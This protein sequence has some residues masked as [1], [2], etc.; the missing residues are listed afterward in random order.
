MESEKEWVLSQIDIFCGVNYRRR[1]LKLAGLEK[2][3]TVMVKLQVDDIVIRYKSLMDLHRKI[4]RALEKV[5]ARQDKLRNELKFLKKKEKTL[6]RFLGFREN[7]ADMVP[8][9]TET[10]N[11]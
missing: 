4:R 8:Y 3:G 11:R 1:M 10:V 2:E 7:N 5:K 9:A 6:N